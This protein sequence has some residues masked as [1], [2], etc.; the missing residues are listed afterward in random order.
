MWMSSTWNG[1][2]RTAV[3]LLEAHR[4]PR[5]HSSIMFTTD[6]L[7]VVRLHRALHLDDTEGVP[8]DLLSLLTLLSAFHPSKGTF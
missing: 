7:T 5:A 1:F 2:R 6:E 3:V 4:F 8:A